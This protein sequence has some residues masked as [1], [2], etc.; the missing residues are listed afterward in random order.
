MAAPGDAA[1]CHLVAGPFC[2]A[3]CSPYLREPNQTAQATRYARERIPP[4]IT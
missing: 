4:T 3:P 1:R 2:C